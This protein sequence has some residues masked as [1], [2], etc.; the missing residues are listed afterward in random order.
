MPPPL[1]AALL[2]RAAL[3][4]LCLWARLQPASLADAAWLEARHISAGFVLQCAGRTGEAA[5]ELLADPLAFLCATYATHGDVATLV[6]GGERVVLVSD[7][8]TA[9]RI[10]VEDA[11]KWI[12]DGTAFFPNSSLAGNGLLVSDGDVWRRQRRLTNPAFRQAAVRPRSNSP[13]LDCIGRCL[14]ADSC[15]GTPAPW[16]VGRCRC[17]GPSHRMAQKPQATQTTAG[18]RAK[19]V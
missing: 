15:A 2:F 14:A 3:R 4:A 11:D 18:A 8:E 16:R 9:H 1:P 19:H 6:L 13:V 7:P 17:G 12:K 5:P 10:T